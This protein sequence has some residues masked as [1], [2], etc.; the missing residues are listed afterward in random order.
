MKT[1]VV[2]RH[3]KAEPYAETDYARRLTDRGRADAADTGR[4]LAT[5]GI[6]PTHALVSDATRTQETWAEL[7]AS[8]GEGAQEDVS[9]AYYSASEHDLL[10]ALR[11]LPP[12]A[13]CVVLVGHNPTA[14]H[15]ARLLVDGEGDPDV[16]RGLL[17]G[18]PPA[19]VAVLEL[20][21]DWSELT[22][23]GARLTRFHVGRG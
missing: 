21:G 15:V 2:V 16:M 18:F 6:T 12:E 22:E 13:S 7:R 5:A 20:P 10:E 4:F 3:A 11:S 8:L 9:P 19:A 17:E 14:A 1:L 23:G